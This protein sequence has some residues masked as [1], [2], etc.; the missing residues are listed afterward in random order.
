[1][2]IIKFALKEL[3]LSGLAWKWIAAAIYFIASLCLLAIPDDSNIMTVA[4]VM[5]NFFISFICVKK[6]GIKIKVD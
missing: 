6:V 5:A 3:G 2:K 1:M 4:I